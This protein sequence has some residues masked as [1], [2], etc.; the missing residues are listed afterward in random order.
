M[1]VQETRSQARGKSD[2]AIVREYHH[3]CNAVNQIL[4]SW[5]LLKRLEESDLDFGHGSWGEAA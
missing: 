5:G 3:D 4:I 2:V 1:E